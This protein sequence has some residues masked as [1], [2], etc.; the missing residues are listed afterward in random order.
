MLVSNLSVR[1]F[2]RLPFG[3]L[4]DGGYAGL[5]FLIARSADAPDLH[6][7]FFRE[8]SDIHHLTGRYLAVITRSRGTASCS[9]RSSTPRSTAASLT[10]WRASVIGRG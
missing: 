3:T 9:A 7:K 6:M 5:V 1:R 10:M 2:L 8:W 4:S